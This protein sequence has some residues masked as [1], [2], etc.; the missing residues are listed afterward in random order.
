MRVRVN[1]FEA[2]EA[3]CNESVIKSM[4]TLEKEHFIANKFSTFIPNN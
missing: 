4:R 1:V 3:Q 2:V